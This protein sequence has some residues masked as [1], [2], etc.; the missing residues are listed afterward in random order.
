M[1]MGLL[2]SETEPVKAPLMMLT[3]LEHF[4]VR[5]WLSGIKAPV[6]A[7]AFVHSDKWLQV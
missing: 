2:N 5:L 6:Q 7:V 3:L 1:G 4:A